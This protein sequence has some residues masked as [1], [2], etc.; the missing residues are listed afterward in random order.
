MK[1]SPLRQ[2]QLDPPAAS[3]ELLN[4]SDLA[5]SVLSRFC[6]FEKVWS[7]V[8]SP[9]NVEPGQEFGLCYGSCYLQ[10][11]MMT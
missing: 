9:H 6:R 11:I 2:H 1:Q 10:A 5:E 3:L 4:Y 7:P 8:R